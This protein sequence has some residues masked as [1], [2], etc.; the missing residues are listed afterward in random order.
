MA[1]A[2]QCIYQ[3]G[4]AG[5][6]ARHIAE[7]AGV[8]LAAIGYHFGTK[9]RLLTAAL[10][11]ATEIG[12]GDEFEDR[13][14][15][16]AVGRSI[17]AALPAVWSD[18][19]ELFDRNREALVAS[20]ENIIRIHRL[21]AERSHLAAANEQAIADFGTILAE[22]HPTIPPARARSIAWLY[23]LLLNGLVVHWLANPDG[24]LPS[25]H[26]IAAAIADLASGAVE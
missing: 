11:Q 10:T 4:L 21:P 1:G 9:E 16:A 25:G 22:A 13:I 20:V 18:I 3:R 26:E 6:T 2:R 15:T 17:T 7:A 23:L 8:S 12:I 14:R 5:T 24:E 19:G